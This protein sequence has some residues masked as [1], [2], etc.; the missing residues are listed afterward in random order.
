VIVFKCSKCGQEYRVADEYAGKKARCKSCQNINAIP[1]PAV[2]SKGPQQPFIVSSGDSVAAYNDLL[3][4][5][6]QQE[7]TAPA[8]EQLDSK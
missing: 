1:T 8:F 7:K 5:L 6:L 3:Q 4:E 2:K